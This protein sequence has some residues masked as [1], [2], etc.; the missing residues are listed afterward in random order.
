MF[1]FP[2]VQKNC[3]FIDYLPSLPS[4]EDYEESLEK[5]VS[6]KNISHAETCVGEALVY[7]IKI[8]NSYEAT[9]LPEG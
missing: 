5:F 3:H 8:K 6:N 2:L 1:C 7:K 4:K 9:G